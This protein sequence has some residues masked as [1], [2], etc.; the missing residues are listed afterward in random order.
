M[1]VHE[2]TF[3][4]A[5]VSTKKVIVCCGA[6]GVGKTTTSAALGVAAAA[7]GRKVLV[8]THLFVGSATRI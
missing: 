1:I 2:P 3:L 6:G 4:D 8:L 5:L 7:R